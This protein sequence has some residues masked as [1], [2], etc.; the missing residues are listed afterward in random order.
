MTFNPRAYA[1]R[2][3]Q[4]TENYEKREEWREENKH[5]ALPF[6]IE[7]LREYVPAIYPGE[8]AVI[9]APSGD[10]KTKMLKT[11]HRQAQ[12][13]ITASGMR[14]VTVF[15]SQEETTERLLA[16]DIETRGKTVVSSFPSVFIGASFGMDAESIEDIHMTN[17]INTLA[18]VKDSMFAEPMPLAM[19]GYDY[20]QA[21][22]NDPSRKTIVSNDSYRHQVNDNTRRLFKAAQTFKMPLI[23]GSQTDIKTDKNKYDKDIPIPGR[24]DFS[25]ASSIFQIPDFVYT[26]VHM[27]NASTVGKRIE[28]GNW[29]FTVEKNLLFMWFLKA[30]GHNPETTAKGLGKVFPIRIINDEYVYDP[31]HHR[32]MTVGG[33]A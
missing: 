26:F 16:D 31:E 6:F 7:G 25:E 22:P 4:V 18:Y 15:G 14:A 24:G 23:T 29:N 30:R 10:G 2:S 13:Q 11:W 32:A 19:C 21:T 17:F 9:G 1:Q 8:M 12:E 20:L 5:L 27:R 3:D 33:K 28:T